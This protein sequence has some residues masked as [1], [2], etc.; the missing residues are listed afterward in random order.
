MK[1][2]IYT[3][4]STTLLAVT[5]CAEPRL[6]VETVVKDGGG[7]GKLK[8]IARVYLLTKSGKEVAV[9]VTSLE[10]GSFE[11]SVTPTL[12]ENG[13]VEIRELVTQRFGKREPHN[14]GPAK[15]KVSLGETL[16]W[17]VGPL[18]FSTKVSLAK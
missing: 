7:G 11:Y 5:V 13:T 3:L 18:A 15:R 1:T 8:L 12:S 16:E 10:V 9:R 17:F 2:I 6:A 4:L 14:V